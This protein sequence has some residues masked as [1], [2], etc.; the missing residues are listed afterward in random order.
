MRGNYAWESDSLV[1]LPHFFLELM[2]AT[3]RRKSSFLESTPHQLLDKM[4]MRKNGEPKL[5]RK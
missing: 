4:S 3:F 5:F 2:R 1:T